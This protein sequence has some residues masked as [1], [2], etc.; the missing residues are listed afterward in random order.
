LKF[1]NISF[2]DVVAR[3]EAQFGYPYLERKD[4]TVCVSRSRLIWKIIQPGWNIYP[5]GGPRVIRL[6]TAIEVYDVLS[7]VRT[8]GWGTGMGHDVVSQGRFMKRSISPRGN[9]LGALEGTRKMLDGMDRCCMY[10]FWRAGLTEWLL[11]RTK[12]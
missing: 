3:K 9:D 5:V 12:D 11:A 1:S 6:Y 4:S 8:H 10:T 2:G 7:E